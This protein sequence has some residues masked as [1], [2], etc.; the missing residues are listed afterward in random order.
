VILS[1]N[2]ALDPAGIA[3]YCSYQQQAKRYGILPEKLA[4][5]AYLSLALGNKYIALFF[6]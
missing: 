6:R 5:E 3:S 2:Q 4:R 1:G